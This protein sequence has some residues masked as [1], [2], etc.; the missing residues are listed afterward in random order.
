MKK[1]CKLLDA[2]YT[3][4]LA[5]FVLACIAMLLVQVGCLI[6]MNGVASA[7]IKG[8]IIPKAGVVASIMVVAVVILSYLRHTTQ[9]DD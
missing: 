7:W 9:K 1:F 4:C 6:T 3:I 8:Y 5:V 2:I